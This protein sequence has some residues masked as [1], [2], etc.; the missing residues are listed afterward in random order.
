MKIQV[1]CLAFS[2][3]NKQDRMHQIKIST[4]ELGLDIPLYS[5]HAIED[6]KI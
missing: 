1:K 6:L 5:E 4:Q 3:K 2:H